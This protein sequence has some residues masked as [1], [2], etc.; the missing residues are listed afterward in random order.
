MH[1]VFR[2]SL[3]LVPCRFFFFAQSK[4][5]LNSKDSILISLV[6]PSSRTTKCLATHALVIPYFSF[7]DQWISFL[8][9]DFFWATVVV[10]VE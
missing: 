10:E 7:S 8:L 2:P 5:E 6:H 1:T 3:A 4:I 9:F